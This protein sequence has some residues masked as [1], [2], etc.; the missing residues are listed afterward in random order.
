MN[1]RQLGRLAARQGTRA[2]L[3]VP[4]VRGLFGLSITVGVTSAQA[5]DDAPADASTQVV[6]TLADSQLTLRFLGTFSLETQ[7]EAVVWARRSASAVAAYLGRFPVNTVDLM[8]V[9]TEGERVRS[10][11]TMP[12]AEQNAKPFVRVNVGR[13]TTAAAFLDDWILVHEMV[14]LAI[15]RLPR[16]QGWLHEGLATYVEGVARARAGITSAAQFWGEMAR[17]LPQGLPK[18]GDQG[19]NNTRTWGRTYWGGALFCLLADV[20]MH[21]KRMGQ[22]DHAGRAGL[23]QA[24]QGVLAAGG[25]YAVA[26]PAERIL[27]VADAAVDQSTLTDLYNTMKD[28]PVPVDLD[29]LWRE[30][31]VADFA[32][33]RAGYHAT[34]LDNASAASVRRAITSESLPTTPTSS[35]PASSS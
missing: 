27:A 17:G 21:R 3:S 7:R 14:H 26:W 18:A 15:P 22:A 2:T 29:G 9:P 33:A 8:L 34:L 10:G 19:L 11:V 23:Q 1:R 31:G 12:G 35:A 13:D 16:N 30:L 20:A 5:A 32:T 6:L 28:Q 4:A 25:S 24:L